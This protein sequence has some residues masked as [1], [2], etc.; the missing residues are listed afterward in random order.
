MQRGTL[1]IA[2]VCGMVGLVAGRASAPARP[3]VVQAAPAAAPVVRVAPGP[4][5]AAPL[6]RVDPR[7]ED[8]ADDAGDG[9]DLA[10]VLASLRDQA[11]ERPDRR[12]ILGH[13]TEAASNEPAVGATVVAV[14]PNLP[15]EQV[16]ITDQDGNYRITDLPAGYYQL[17]VYYDDTTTQRRDVAAREAS[18]TELDVQLDPRREPAQPIGIEEDDV[19]NVPVGRTF[20]AALGAAADSQDDEG[21]TFSSVA[22]IETYVE[23]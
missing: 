5:L 21:A 6:A 3:I 23:N 2:G 11:S 4:A 12:A 17:T 14:S 10:A 15:G 8:G 19:V 13:V 16:V 22:T 20:E 18:A 9:T 7:A 1:W